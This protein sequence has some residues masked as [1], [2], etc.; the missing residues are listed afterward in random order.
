MYS[1]LASRN[2][3]VRASVKPA[4]FIVAAICSGVRYSRSGRGAH[5]TMASLPDRFSALRALRMRVTGSS[6]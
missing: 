5:S 3:S 2:V 1:P 6:K 4:R